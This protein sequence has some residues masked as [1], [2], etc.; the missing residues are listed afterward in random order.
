VKQQECVLIVDD[1]PNML[2][3]LRG[4]L[5]REGYLT[6]EASNGERALELLDDHPVDAILS[7]FKMPHMNGLEL[8]HAVQRRQLQIPVILLTAHGTI[9]GAVEALKQGAFDYLTKPFDPDEIH[10]IVA[11]AVRTHALQKREARVADPQNPDQLLLGESSRL[12]EVKRVIERVA[13]TPATVLITGESG[14]GKELVARSLHLQS[15]RAREAFVKINCAAIPEGLLESELFGHEKGAF[16]GAARRK[17]GRFELAHGGTLFL[18]EI[19]EMPLA[20]QP[21]LLRV[22]QDGRFYHVGGTHTIEVDVRLIAATNR[23]LERE[24]AKGRFRED[25]FYRLNV[26]PIRLPP[27]RERR[28]DIPVLARSFAARFG[29]QHRGVACILTAEAEASL[30]SYSWPGNIRELEN[31]IERAVLL[32]EDT[33]LRAGDLPVQLA[34]ARARGPGNAL[35]RDR[36]R[37]ETR[38]IEREAIQEALRVTDGNVTQAARQLGLSRRGL[39]LKMKELDI[40]RP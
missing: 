7:D 24:V 3:V 22:L 40:E 8:L 39:Q 32:A 10:Q 6:Y 23:D 29:V 33:E 2:R 21:K 35:L 14:T 25:L 13:R 36:V 16:T 9:G 31:T 17:M 27:L 4:L 34:P 20:S 1:E 28:E 19:G 30:C 15:T 38:R 11:K 37:H 5:R 26:L 12:R 18:D